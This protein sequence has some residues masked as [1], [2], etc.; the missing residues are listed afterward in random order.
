MKAKPPRLSTEEATARALS[1][2]TRARQLRT[3][4]EAL[5]AKAERYERWAAKWADW[6]DDDYG[7][8]PYPEHAR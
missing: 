4:A 5:L 7:D 8:V 1:H 2:R 3:E 6:A